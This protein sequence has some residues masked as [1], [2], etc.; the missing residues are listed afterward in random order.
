M[1]KLPMTKKILMLTMMASKSK[2]LHLSIS[3]TKNLSG[4]KTNKT[5]T[6]YH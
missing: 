3:Q 2:R 4:I 5:K 6:S 1:I